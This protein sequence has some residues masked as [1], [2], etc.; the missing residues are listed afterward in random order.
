MG[1]LP[2]AHCGHLAAAPSTG[3]DLRIKSGGL[4]CASGFFTFSRREAWR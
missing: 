2:P 3:F 1:N 4:R